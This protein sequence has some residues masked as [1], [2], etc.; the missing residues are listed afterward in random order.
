MDGGMSTGSGTKE[1]GSDYRMPDVLGYVSV[2]MKRSMGKDK[3][4]HKIKTI[5]CLLIE[6]KLCGMQNIKLM[7]CIDWFMNEIIILK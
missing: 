5:A 3:Y 1:G 4:L 6:L 7:L 2:W